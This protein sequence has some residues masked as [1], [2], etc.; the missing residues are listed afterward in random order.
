MKR[1][2]LLSEIASAANADLELLTQFISDECTS[3]DRHSM[4]G[5]VEPPEAIGIHAYIILET[6]LSSTIDA[7]QIIALREQATEARKVTE[8]MTREGIDL[9]LDDLVCY[10]EDPV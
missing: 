4:F 10:P 7:D 9:F 8:Y 3:D 6:D 1:I 5:P 2:N